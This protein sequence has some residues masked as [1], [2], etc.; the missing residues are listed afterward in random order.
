MEFSPLILFFYQRAELWIFIKERRW[1][2]WD[3]TEWSRVGCVRGVSLFSPLCVLEEGPSAAD[4]GNARAVQT[5]T[6]FMAR[7]CV[8]PGRFFPRNGFY[9][10]T[11][12]ILN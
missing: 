10:N 1:C 7:G 12:K 6:C 2:E 5:H 3:W 9:D 4:G 11:V 8:V